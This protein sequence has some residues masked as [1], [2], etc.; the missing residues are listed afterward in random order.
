MYLLRFLFLFLSSFLPISL[1]CTSNAFSR[2]DQAHV[3]WSGARV[4]EAAQ[5]LGAQRAPP[6]AQ[7]TQEEVILD[8][9][10]HDSE[11]I[12]SDNFDFS[13]C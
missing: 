3:P 2:L 5:V 1:S 4:P 13:F 9:T 12:I 10:I 6:Q 7:S 11:Q 8:C